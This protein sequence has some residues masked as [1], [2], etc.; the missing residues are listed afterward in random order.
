[1][2]SRLTKR[3]KEI[4]VEECERQFEFIQALKRTDFFKREI[5]DKCERRSETGASK[6]GRRERGHNSGEEEE[7]DDEDDDNE[8]DEEYDEFDSSTLDEGDYENDSVSLSKEST[9]NDL[10]DKTSQRRRGSESPSVGRSS[11]IT[12]FQLQSN[13]EIVQIEICET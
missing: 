6:A 9:S 4:I 3:P 8:E 2:S 13:L 10:R 7:D 12:F 5:G 1:M 11:G